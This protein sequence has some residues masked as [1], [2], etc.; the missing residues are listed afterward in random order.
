[1]KQAKNSFEKNEPAL[2]KKNPKKA[3]VEHMENDA[4]PNV[5]SVGDKNLAK[6][7]GQPKVEGSSGVP[8]KRK[9]EE[10]QPATNVKRQK[11][12]TRAPS[13]P[14]EA[15][16]FD[17]LS[18]PIYDGQDDPEA[19]YGYP[20]EFVQEE[21]AYP[22]GEYPPEAYYAE[23]DPRDFRQ[24]E[25]PPRPE[26]R[27]RERSTDREKPTTERGKGR[28]SQ[29][30]TSRSRRGD[31]D[32]SKHDR[33]GKDKKSS[34]SGHRSSRS[35]SSHDDHEK[36]ADKDKEKDK[37]K[38]RVERNKDREKEKGDK[39]KNR[40]DKDDRDKAGRE[41]NRKDKDDREDKEKKIKLE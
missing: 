30:V 41:N 39:E 26:Y 36:S 11:K 5:K 19:Y 12:D 33:D 1:M 25:R 21:F 31:R 23:W 35:R 7:R 34:R 24:F 10:I 9:I 27:D 22:E 20:M 28:D 8:Q 14:S 13:I 3:A 6:R 15:E 37:S 32:K 38:D 2:K 18:I 16:N 17:F 4:P 29:K 40:K